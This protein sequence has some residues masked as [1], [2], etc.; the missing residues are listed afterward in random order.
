LILR[1]AEERIEKNRNKQLATREDLNPNL[2]FVDNIVFREFADNVALAKDFED[3]HINWSEHRDRFT[4]IFRELIETEEYQ[5]YMTSPKGIREDKRMVKFIYGTYIAGNEDIH[6]IYEEMNMHWADDL[7][8]AQMMVVKTIKVM[9]DINGR[10]ISKVNFDTATSEEIFKT[11]KL[12]ADFSAK[13]Q[14]IT[15]NLFKDKSDKMFGPQ[16]F[17]KTLNNSRDQDILITQ[18][19][20]NWEADRI[21][22]IDNVLMKM[23][24]TELTEF[25]EIPVRV[26]LNEY[27]ELS[28]MYSTPKSSQFING[29]LDQISLA[30]QSE[31]KIKKIGRGLM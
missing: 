4:K 23:A 28:K 13:E 3:N 26:S 25:K 10:A 14:K 27:I 16:L 11:K 9:M 18:K 17:T 6:A 19:T 20:K 24:Q 31:G 21:A 12:P 7:D 22:L 2:R 8:A 30:L 15:V 5:R 29:V 1:A